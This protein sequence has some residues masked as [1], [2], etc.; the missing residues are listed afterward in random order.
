[1]KT[2]LKFVSLLW[3]VALLTGN[4]RSAN[5]TVSLILDHDSAKPGETVLAG[6]R[7]QMNPGWHTYWKNSGR[8]G[9]PTVIKWKLPEGV[10]A[11]SILWPLP[12][13]LPDPDFTTYVYEDEAVLL[14]PLKISANAP[15]GQMIIK[16]KAAWQECEKYCTHG[17]GEVQA[18]LEI[19]AESKISSSSSL[20]NEWK[21]KT[22]LSLPPDSVSASWEKGNSNNVRNLVIRLT[23]DSGALRSDFLPYISDTYDTKVEVL[24][25]AGVLPGRGFQKTIKNDNEE[26]PKEVPGVLIQYLPGEK[27]VTYEVT[28]KPTLTKTDA[29]TA[30]PE[31]SPAALPIVARDERS[32]LLMLFNA[33]VGGLILNVMPCVLPVIALKIL[34]FVHETKSAPEKM[35]KLGLVYGAGVLASFLAL[36][37]MVISVKQLGHAA[38][39]GMQFQN[40]QFV[41]LMTTLVLLVALN[42]FGVFEVNLSGGIMGTAGNLASKSGYSGAF[43]NGVLATILATPCTAPFL[44]TALGFAFLQ[45][46]PII[47]LIFLTVGAGVASPYIVLSFKPSWLKF[48][49]KPGVWMEKFKMIMGFPMLATVIWLFTLATPAFGDNGDLFLGL[50]L[51]IVG[52]IAFIW[53]QFVQRGRSGQTTAMVVCAMIAFAAYAYFL[54]H[55]LHWRHP[56]GVSASTKTSPQGKDGID[57]QPWS[58]EAVAEARKLGHPILVDF[59]AKWCLV[60]QLN[61][62]SSIE[63]PEVQKRLKDLHAIAFIEDSYEKNDVVVHELNSHQRA[64]VPLVLVYP[65]D[66]SKPPVVLPELLTP[67]IVLDALDAAAKD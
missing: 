39:W 1:M 53:G 63:I 20:L 46:A 50:F 35:K 26:W 22:P 23:E 16:A 36:A 54:E 61:K 30:K 10:T 51:V 3:L 6:I 7:L 43:M 45:P 56:A 41:V 62:K 31:T 19:G 24:P 13:V 4:A 49:P 67:S 44:G 48:L 28:L 66:P 8:S 37:V 34:G 15:Q 17:D 5:T 12:H 29:T 25:L 65:K 27:T 2:F 32:L 42:L 38:S 18:S 59:T 47:I 64:G 14:V 40:S 58:S 9:E 55:Q 11:G 57:W 52:L 33:F 21:N 60:C